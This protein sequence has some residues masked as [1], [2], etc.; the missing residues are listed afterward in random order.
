MQSNSLLNYLGVPQWYPRKSQ[1]PWYQ[2]DRVIVEVFPAIFKVKC[3]VLLPMQKSN[4]KFYDPKVNKVLTGML[5]VLDLAPEELSIAKIYAVDEQLTAQDWQQVLLEVDRFQ[6]KFVLQLDKTGPL[7]R[8][9]KTWLQTYHPD[10]LRHN[11]QDKV[12]AYHD[13]LTLKNKIL[14]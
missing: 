4:M 6:P 9:D 5:G 2:E 7:G 12:A 10:H 3:L 8:N 1:H 13:L 11:Q 14:P